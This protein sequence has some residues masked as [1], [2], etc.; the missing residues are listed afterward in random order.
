MSKPICNDPIPVRVP[1][2][3]LTSDLWREDQQQ[4]ATADARIRELTAY[5]LDRLEAEVLG[6][7]GA[8]G[9]PEERLRR[10]ISAYATLAIT[11]P[12]I[13]PLLSGKT[14]EPER[15]P[16]IR[17]RIRRFTDTLEKHLGEVIRTQNRTPSIDPQVAVQSLL[18]IIHW[19]VCSHRAEDRLSCEEASAQITFLA[20]HGLVAGPPVRLPARRRGLHAA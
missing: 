13:M 16:A 12:G 11:D 8:S 15:S 6:S 18:G 20:L 3:I 1:G 17:L 10:M 5:R 2:R 19:G 7:A 14:A 9:R 4:P